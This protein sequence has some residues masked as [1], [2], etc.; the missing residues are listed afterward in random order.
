MSEQGE[1][2]LGGLSTDYIAKVQNRRHKKAIELFLRILSDLDTTGFTKQDVRDAF[3]NYTR[4]YKPSIQVR[5]GQKDLDI[6]VELDLLDC[7]VESEEY[8]VKNFP[9]EL[10]STD[11][12][13]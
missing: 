11:F 13:L 4:V 2:V 7:D 10:D 9:E 5:F 6:L 1:N 12:D 3:N 8:S